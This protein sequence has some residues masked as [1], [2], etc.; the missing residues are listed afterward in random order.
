MVFVGQVF[1][2][3]PEKLVSRTGDLKSSTV[4]AC[5]AKLPQIVKPTKWPIISTEERCWFETE[6]IA[7]QPIIPFP[8]MNLTRGDEDQAAA[9]EREASAVTHKGA[10]A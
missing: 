7:V 3:D 9:S 1:K 8:G 2:C 10:I 6:N 5:R 4:F